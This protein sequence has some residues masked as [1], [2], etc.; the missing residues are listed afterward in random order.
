MPNFIDISGR[1]FFRLTVISRSANKC[2]RAH[3][4]C[5]CACGAEA[6]VAANKLSSGHT[7]S[8]GCLQ[9]E[10]SSSYN[11]THGASCYPNGGRA[12]KEYNTWGLMRRRCNNPQSA[13][14][15]LYGGR[16]IKVCER[17]ESSFSLFLLDMGA[18]PSEKHSI[19][20]ID[21]N[22]DYCKENCRWADAK[23]Q[24]RN[25]RGNRFLE[26]RGETK[27]PMEWAEI[28]GVSNKRIYARIKRGWTVEAA[29]F[30]PT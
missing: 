19:D 30:T 26:C 14:F 20:R 11:K 24:R 21:A 2:G 3:W 17:W 16:G 8:C 29:I 23:T 25:Q 6:V 12:T 15:P 9:R 13:G 4:L 1:V 27:T 10:T 28:S 5:A 18:A 22:G 7:R